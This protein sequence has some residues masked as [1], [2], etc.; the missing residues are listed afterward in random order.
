MDNYKAEKRKVHDFWAFILFV[1][2]GITVNFL[3]W[4]QESVESNILG[5]LKMKDYIYICACIYGTIFVM[6]VGLFFFPKILMHISCLVLPLL[7]IFEGFIVGFNFNGPFFIVSL[8][9][10]VLS[11]I[12]YYFFVMKH[13][14]YSAVVA[15]AGTTVLFNNF[16]TLVLMVILG[17]VP[18][19]VQSIYAFSKISLYS[20]NFSM[21]IAMVIMQGYWVTYFVFYVLRVMTGTLTYLDIVSRD[22]TLSNFYETAKNTLFAVGSCALGS[23]LIALVSTLKWC[24]QRNTDNNRDNLFAKIIQIIAL[25]LLQILGSIIKTLNTW[26][27]IYLAIYGTSYKN[28]LSQSFDL[29]TQRNSHCLINSFCMGSVISLFICIASVAFFSFRVSSFRDYDLFT[30]EL[31]VTEIA[32]GY[33]IL[34]GIQNGLNCFLSASHTIMLTYEIDPVSVEQKYSKAA[35]ALA[36]QKLKN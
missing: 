22:N 19:A 14:K 1:I 8:I 18:C 2:Y 16:T 26:G 5:A 36:E 20:D 21:W 11:L 6:G 15:K 25:I 27:F 28:S 13:V 29:I 3:L 24:V 34:V 9:S 32:I 12:F 30:K 23:F 35:K 10:S 4:M 17:T 7:S 33:I 31:I